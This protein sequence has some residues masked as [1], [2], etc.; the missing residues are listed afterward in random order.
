MSSRFYIFGADYPSSMKEDVIN[1][2][3]VSQTARRILSWHNGK[4][5]PERIGILL[6]PEISNREVIR[7]FSTPTELFYAY[8]K[9]IQ[10]GIRFDEENKWMYHPQKN[11][12]KGKLTRI[13][14]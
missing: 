2:Q 13:F 3:E 12:R 11:L 5:V 10:E 8:G 7:V 9:L 6:P 1:F 14:A 4:V